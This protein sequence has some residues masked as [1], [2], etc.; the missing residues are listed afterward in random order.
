MTCLLTLAY[1]CTWLHPQLSSMKS[2][3]STT[4]ACPVFLTEVHNSLPAFSLWEE[5]PPLPHA[6]VPCTVVSV[7]MMKEWSCYTEEKLNDS[8]LN[9]RQNGETDHRFPCSIPESSSHC[10]SRKRIIYAKPNSPLINHCQSLYSHITYFHYATLSKYLF[11]PEQCMCKIIFYSD[12]FN[13]LPAW[14]VLLIVYLWWHNGM[15]GAMLQTDR[16]LTVWNNSMP[17]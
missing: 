6:G 16:H 3:A 13:W 7:S 2:T 10:K 4:A 11:H 9:P 5:G 15:H 14:S 1:M 8:G 17:H 12:L